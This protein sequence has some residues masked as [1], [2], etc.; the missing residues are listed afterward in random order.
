MNARSVLLAAAFSA[1]A[2]ASAARPSSARICARLRKNFASASRLAPAGGAASVGGIA[3]PG[4]FDLL[5]EWA[6][7]GARAVTA[8]V[9]RS[10]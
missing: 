3:L 2:M 5:L 8:A 9:G 10:L 1:S 4:R 7:L 6:P